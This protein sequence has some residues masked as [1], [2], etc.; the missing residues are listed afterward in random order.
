MKT[1]KKRLKRL[2]SA[3]LLLLASVLIGIAGLML[4]EGLGFWESFYLSVVIISTVGMNE[5]REVSEPGRIFITFYIIFNLSVFAYFVSIITKYIFEGELREIFQTYM[6]NRV[7][8]KMKGH[9]IVCGYGRNGSKTCEQLQRSNIPFA[10]IER[11]AST[12]GGHFADNSNVYLVQGDATS[13]EILLAAGIERA[14]TIITTL[15]KDADNVF[16]ALT[17]RELNPN[18]KIVARAAEYSSINKL[19]RAGAHHVVMP[20]AIGGMHMANLV[21]RPEVVEFLDV[22]NGV[23][24]DMQLDELRFN[25]MK[26]EFRGRSIRDMKVRELTGITILGYKKGGKN[27]IFNPHPDTVFAEND[28]LIILGTELEVNKFME[29]FGT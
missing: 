15:P 1:L 23:E 5:V 29:V 11:D 13:D 20:D 26:K 4:I 16:V 8:D 19:H 21:T 10:L 17:A 22:L 9:I 3:F 18:I 7:A 14:G 6:V 2:V 12:V 24:S 28:V 27:F 25:D